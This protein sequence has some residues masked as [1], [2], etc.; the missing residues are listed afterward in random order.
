MES[1]GLR[2]RDTHA[3]AVSGLR[4]ITPLIGIKQPLALD[5]S[6]ALR[7]SRGQN[8]SRVPNGAIASGDIRQHNGIGPD[9]NVITDGY[10]TK[11]HSTWTNGD[12]ITQTRV[13]IVV[14]I[15][16]TSIPKGETCVL[17][18]RQVSPCPD[19]SS[20]NANRVRDV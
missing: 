15:R 9:Q 13:V 16:E 12:V 7:V 18:E 14:L 6:V 3:A 11:K 19:W 1:V 5:D 2:D 17:H 20:H 8:P 10:S 4:S